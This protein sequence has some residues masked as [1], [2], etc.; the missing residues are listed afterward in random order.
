MNLKVMV[1][2]FSRRIFSCMSEIRIR[3]LDLKCIPEFYFYFTVGKFND[4]N[5][6]KLLLLYFGNYTYSRMN[7]VSTVSLKVIK[8]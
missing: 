4:K 1:K 7:L 5:Y 8:L 6:L 3:D 2:G